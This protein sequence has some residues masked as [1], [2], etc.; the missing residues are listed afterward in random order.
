MSLVEGESLS[1]WL[2]AAILIDNDTV[3]D[4]AEILIKVSDAVA[5][6]HS[7]SVIHCDLK[8]ANI[9][10]GAFGQVYVRDGGGAG[11]LD[12]APDK[13]GD[14]VVVN[15]A[16]LP[17]HMTKGQLFGTPS[18]IAPV[19]ESASRAASTLAKTVLRRSRTFWSSTSLLRAAAK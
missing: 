8:P 6:A 10:I 17:A 16:P 4:F 3:V 13:G 11:V 12:A 1:R 19:Y 9:M 18:Y 7:R 5:Y 2:R 15:L 14:P